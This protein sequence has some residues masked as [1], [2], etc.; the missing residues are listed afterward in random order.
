M[1]TLS[2]NCHRGW[3]QGLFQSLRS[4]PTA[5][6]SRS[7]CGATW[8]QTLLGHLV[9]ST[10]LWQACLEWGGVGGRPSHPPHLLGRIMRRKSQTLGV[11]KPE[12]QEAKQTDGH[13][14]CQILLSPIWPQ[15]DT[16]RK[17]CL[18]T[19]P[20]LSTLGTRRTWAL[21]SNEVVFLNGKEKCFGA[22]F[23]F[24]KWY[25]IGFKYA[26]KL[27]HWKPVNQ[28]RTVPFPTFR[29]YMKWIKSTGMTW[30]EL[31]H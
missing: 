29:G 17:P 18:M 27:V 11:R 8:E 26:K 23:L 25:M 7:L 14:S 9:W 12:G 15:G 16:L 6:L 3:S 28:E 21:T 31:G 24:S 1:S 2:Q 10:C 19:S 22:Y 20:T 5:L 13:R 4:E 30:G